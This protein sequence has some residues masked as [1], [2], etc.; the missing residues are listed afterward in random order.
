MR[1]RA[2][3]L[4]LPLLGVAPALAASA[5]GA[6]IA[7]LYSGLLGI[8]KQGKSVPF[9]TRFA[10]IAPVVERTFDL[11]RILRLA[12]GPEWPSLPPD[13]KR[14]LGKLF[15]AFT[16][17]SYVANFNA[18]SGE[19]LVVEAG[20]RAV[21]PERV[22]RTEI[23]GGDGSKNRIDYVMA[24]AKAGWQVVDVLLDGTISQ[25]AIQRSE[26]SGLVSTGNAGRL[27][28]ALK[29][30]IGQLSGGTLSG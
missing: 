19:K 16:I 5:V 24:P 18:F 6:P 23:I 3:L 20:A 1:R 26:Y 10:A 21:G 11:P 13:Q 29:T 12:V 7:A 17:A 4:A 8:M 15:A 9:T 14:R 28:A 2:L 22:V 27:I 25:L 30:K